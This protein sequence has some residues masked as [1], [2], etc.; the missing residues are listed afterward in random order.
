MASL[1]TVKGILILD[2]DGNRVLSKYYDDSMPTVKEQRAFEKKLFQKTNQSSA[3]IVMFE[4]ITCVFRSN[5]DLIFYVFGSSQENELLLATVL[6]T[7]YDAISIVVRENIEKTTVLDHLDAVMLITDEIVD[8]GI[9]LEADPETLAVNATISSRDE[10]PITEQT[11]AQA[12]N[13]AGDILRRH[14]S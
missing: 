4:G 5:I 10:G 14:L 1:Y 8:G 12:W 3:E 13:K 7:L 6:N 2:N 9:V 11:L